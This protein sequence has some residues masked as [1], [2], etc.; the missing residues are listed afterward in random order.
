MMNTAN[1]SQGETS[2]QG[3]SNALNNFQRGS[4]VGQMS[5]ISGFKL[6]EDDFVRGRRG[7]RCI[8]C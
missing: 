8:L 6:E 4:F 7:S 1:D 5:Q 2:N 3:E